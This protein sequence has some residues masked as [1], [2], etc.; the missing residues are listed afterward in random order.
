M[1]GLGNDIM[2]WL[3]YMDGALHVWRPHAVSL[4]KRLALILSSCLS[5]DSCH[6]VKSRQESTFFAAF[7][8]FES[9]RPCL[10]KTISEK[11]PWLA[12]QQIYIV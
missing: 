10:E 11:V 1:G 4:H 6:K 9:L 5:F 3:S 12:R 8:L 2:L 7:E